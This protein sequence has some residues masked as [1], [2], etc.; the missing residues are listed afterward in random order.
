[1]TNETQL[2]IEAIQSYDIYKDTVQAF[3][4]TYIPY[5]NAITWLSPV[6]DY[7]A[8][9]SLEITKTWTF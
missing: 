4:D 3:V 8:T 9:G 7:I 1:M 5:P 6:I 2:F